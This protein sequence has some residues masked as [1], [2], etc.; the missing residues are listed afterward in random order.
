[1][2]ESHARAPYALISP[3]EKLVFRAGDPVQMLKDVAAG[4]APP[5]EFTIISPSTGGP[6]LYGCITSISRPV[7]PPNRVAATIVAAL[8]G[9]ERDQWLGI[10]GLCGTR[11]AHAADIVSSGPSW[12]W[13]DD[14]VPNRIPTCLGQAGR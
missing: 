14:A 3:T 13:P 8:G 9:P 5:H 6:G 2:N 7:A 11:L 12:Q 1:M 4:N 10:I